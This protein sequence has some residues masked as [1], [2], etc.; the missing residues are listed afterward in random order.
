MLKLIL[1]LKRLVNLKCLAAP[2]YKG[3]MIFQ[4][5]K[6]RAH[7]LPLSIP[8]IEIGHATIE[9]L[10]MHVLRKRPTPFWL[11]SQGK[12]KLLLYCENV[13]VFICW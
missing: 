1:K 7:E 10:S 11:R 12:C 3:F 8:E 13:E 4:L 2:L 6:V 9:L 5:Q